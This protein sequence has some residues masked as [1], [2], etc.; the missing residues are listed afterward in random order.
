MKW[1]FYFSKGGKFCYCCKWKK[2]RIFH[3][4]WSD[5]AI[6]DF[7]KIDQQRDHVSLI[8][9]DGTGFDWKIILEIS[10]WLRI[11]R[12]PLTIQSIGGCILYARG[13]LRE[14]YST[15]LNSIKAYYWF[16]GKFSEIFSIH[17][18]EIFSTW[19]VEM[20]FCPDFVFVLKWWRLN[21]WKKI[22]NYFLTFFIDA[23]NL[24]VVVAFGRNFLNFW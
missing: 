17:D 13:N 1:G 9:F 19:D 20:R 6:R 3:S 12:F 14:C 24:D 7:T 10:N 23:P 5:E 4:I 22:G 11:L 15:L 8:M 18:I 16:H 21:F 2:R